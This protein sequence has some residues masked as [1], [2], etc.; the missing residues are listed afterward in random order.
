MFRVG[1]SPALARRVIDV[2]RHPNP[3]RTGRAQQLARQYDWARVG[4]AVLSVYRATLAAGP[5]SHARAAQ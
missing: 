4:A 5:A 2:L 1:D 3:E